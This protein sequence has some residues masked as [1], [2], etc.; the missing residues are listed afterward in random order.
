MKYVQGIWSDDCEYL[1]NL[2]EMGD[3]NG[4]VS[5]KLDKACVDRDS[6]ELEVEQTSRFS[7]YSVVPQQRENGHS[8]HGAF[9]LYEVDKP[10]S[11]GDETLEAVT[12][13]RQGHR[14]HV[15]RV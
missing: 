10:D 2:K 9:V 14:G 3:C 8:K 7:A 5:P 11:V 15:N 12:E 13:I 6:E 4:S 1:K